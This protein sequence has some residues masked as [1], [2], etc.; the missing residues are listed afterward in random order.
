MS[1]KPQTASGYQPEHMA[2]VKGTCL[3]VATVLGDLMDEITIVGGLV[4]PLLI[5]QAG[6]VERADP[7]PGTMD[8][9]IGF[10]LAVLKEKRYTEVSKR[11]KGAGFVP[12]RTEQ[13][14]V[15]R[16]TWWI[17]VPGRPVGPSRF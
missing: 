17:E 1:D 13:G 6:G 11:L 7:Y 10:A 14:R 8:L 12:G 15:T 2:L 3:Y 9:D 4:P 16:Q 5:S